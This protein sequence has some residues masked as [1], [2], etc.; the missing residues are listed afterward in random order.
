MDAFSY[1]RSIDLLYAAGLRRARDRQYVGNWNDGVHGWITSGKNI[2]YLS[3]W[4]TDCKHVKAKRDYAKFRNSKT[5]FLVQCVGTADNRRV[6]PYCRCHGC[7]VVETNKQPP[8]VTAI[9]PQQR[10][11]KR[12]AKTAA[13]HVADVA[14][15]SHHHHCQRP[16]EPLQRPSE[17][18]DS[19]SDVNA[20][21]LSLK[22]ENDAKCPQEIH[23]M[24]SSDEGPKCAAWS[25][26]V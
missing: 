10:P 9:P 12:P 17:T 8:P 16:D 3:R 20:S 19:S 21:S 14:A 22:S 5:C 7:V 2:Y 6:L 15:Q 11:T 18:T 1:F 23:S 24:N 13:D 26:Q 25:Y 4:W